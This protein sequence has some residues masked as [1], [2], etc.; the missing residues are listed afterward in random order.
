MPG[1]H[2]SRATLTAK[3][4]R[5]LR[6]ADRERTK[7]R[8]LR[9][10]KEEEEKT[11]GK[12]LRTKSTVQ[13]PPSPGECLKAVEKDEEEEEQPS[14]PQLASERIEVPLAKK[15]CRLPP[16]DIVEDATA[17]LIIQPPPTIK[18]KE[19]K[20][21]VLKC[22]MQLVPSTVDKHGA[23]LGFAIMGAAFDYLD[24]Y[25]AKLCDPTVHPTAAAKVAFAL[26]HAA[27]DGDAFVLAGPANEGARRLLDE[28]LGVRRL[29]AQ[30]TTGNHSVPVPSTAFPYS[31][32]STRK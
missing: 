32:T 25:S 9:R 31:V 15:V 6:K 30:G 2:L 24:H 3:R 26:G 20:T 23:S 22:L 12:R 21:K 28:V 5:E 29:G 19:K 17:D 1:A 11:R 10:K 27:H 16:R 8:L 18:A 7:R 14:L 4:R 13:K